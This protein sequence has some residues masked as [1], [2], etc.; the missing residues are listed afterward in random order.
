M[1]Q[2]LSNRLSCVTLGTFLQLSEHQFP[3][4]EMGVITAHW[5]QGFLKKRMRSRR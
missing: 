5:L 4:V 2:E 1:T 3:N